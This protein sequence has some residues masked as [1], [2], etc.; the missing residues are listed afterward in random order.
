MSG[1][2]SPEAFRGYF[3]RRVPHEGVAM[4]RCPAK[5]RVRAVTPRRSQH[6]RAAHTHRLVSKKCPIEHPNVAR[7]ATPARNPA[8]GSTPALQNNTSTCAKLSPAKPGCLSE[9]GAGQPLRAAGPHAQHRHWHVP[10]LELRRCS[11][12]TDHARDIHAQRV[13]FRRR[14]APPHRRQRRRSTVRVA[15]PHH[16]MPAQCR[17]IMH[18]LQADTAVA[19]SGGGC[20]GRRS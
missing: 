6:G 17:Q 12:H 5:V 19:R 11:L 1:K 7:S 16:N 8:D 13:E 14:S 9:R 10:R 4:G 15:A 2:Q 18:N 3:A 20:N